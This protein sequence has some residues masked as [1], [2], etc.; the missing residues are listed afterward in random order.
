MAHKKCLEEILSFWIQLLVVKIYGIQIYWMQTHQ[1]ADIACNILITY[2]T[3]FLTK[4][5]FSIK[6]KKITQNTL[7]L[8]DNISPQ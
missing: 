8:N 1:S 2:D 4:R 5:Y 7:Y 6:E 3:M